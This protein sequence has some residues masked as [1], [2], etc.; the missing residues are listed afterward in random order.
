MTLD[1]QLRTAL[2][3]PARVELAAGPI[4]YHAMGEG[5]P[6][7]ALHG[8]ALHAGFWRKVVPELA[9][10]FRCI[11]PTLPLG[12]H[13]LAMPDGA[14]L[15]PP[16]LARLIADLLAA[17]D[18]DDVVILANDTGG[19]LAQ[20]LVTEHPE[21]IGGLVLTPCDAFDNFLP[22]QFRHLQLAARVPGS[23]AGVR[24]FLRLGAARRSPLG[25]GLLTKH[26]IPDEVTASYVAPLSDAGV[27]RDLATVLR[28]IDSQHT[29]RAAEKLGGFSRPALVAWATE[30]KV[31]PLAHGRRLAQLLGDARFELV[32]DSR[33][34][35]PEDQPDALVRLVRDHFGG[36][37]PSFTH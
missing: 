10:T 37:T 22:C 27:R 6:V 25:F 8:L 17:L 4:E 2:G 29:A 9:A 26:G 21:R 24:Q 18:L 7:V 13:R 15:S 5:R 12:A 35:I 1:D 33:T 32:D 30:D 28:G 23:V 11:T 19:A 14:D 34:Y 3:E 31:F 16:G 36:Q 20:I